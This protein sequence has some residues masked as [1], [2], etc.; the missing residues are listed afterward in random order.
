[1]SAPR[2]SL[3]RKSRATP[4]EGWPRA[5][6]IRGSGQAGQGRGRVQ[7]Q[8]SQPQPPARPAQLPR[9]LDGRV[10]VHRG[11]RDRGLPRRRRDCRRTGGAAAHGPVRDP[12]AVAV[13]AGRQGPQGAG[14][15]PGLHAA[16]Y[17]HRRGRGRRR[18][19]GADVRRL[20]CWRC[21][22][23]SPP[24]ST[25]RRTRPCSRPCATPG[26]ELASANVVRGLLDSAATLVGP[27]LAA[28]LLQVA[29]VPAVFSCRGGGLAVG[30]P[31][32]DPAALRSTPTPVRRPRGPT[33]CARQPRGSARSAGTATWP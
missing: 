7:Q 26:Y 2:R 6:R 33:C 27:L 13:A 24:R 18:A 15:D 19:V 14:A 32:A 31:P 21:C 5:G 20:R 29:G 16:R 12:G 4:C 30:G 17:R 1:M 22:R 23:R 11:P 25:V 28:V 9:G 10:G 3:Q 8:R